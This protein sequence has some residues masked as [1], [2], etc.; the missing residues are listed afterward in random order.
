MYKYDLVIQMLSS[1]VNRINVLFSLKVL[2]QLRAGFTEHKNT[3]IIHF[4]SDNLFF[5]GLTI[6]GNTLAQTGQFCLLST[7]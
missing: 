3:L 1:M 7:Q 6:M 2:K 4:N 5:D